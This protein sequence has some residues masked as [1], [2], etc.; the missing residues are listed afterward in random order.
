MNSK[1]VVKILFLLCVLLLVVLARQQLG[2]MSVKQGLAMLFGGTNP[3][4]SVTWCVENTVDVL[5]TNA[6]V[7]EA[8]KDKSLSFMREQYCILQTE[9]I[10]GIE[11]DKVEWAPLAESRGPAGQ[12][13]KLEWSRENEVFRS[14]GMPF[15]STWFAQEIKS[16]LQKQ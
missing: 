10:A 15:K 7:A 9:P 16:N 1:V 11:I 8:M 13:S 4:N 3:K 5:W 2:S 12:I 6:E 14:G